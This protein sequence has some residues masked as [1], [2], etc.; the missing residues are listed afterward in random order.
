MKD[1]EELRVNKQRAILAYGAVLLIGLAAACGGGGSSSNPG[2]GF[3]PTTPAPT[4]VGSATPTPTPTPPTIASQ[5]TVHDLGA[6]RF[7]GDGQAAGAAI[8]GATVI[9]GPTLVVG[10]TPPPT[11]PSGDSAT[12]TAS[13]GS[14][15]IGNYTTTG[16]TY[17]MVF[18]ASGDTAHISLHA[19]AKV[20]NGQIRPLY[21]HSLTA[22]E[23]TELAQINSDRSANGASSVVP[24][25]IA[26]ETARAHADFM[27][28]NGYYQHCIPAAA[29]YTVTSVPTTP[30]ASYA[31]QYVSPDDLYDF[32]NGA[33]QL[34]TLQNQTE[35][36]IALVP[37]WSTADASF[38]AEKGGSGYA[39]HYSNI[40][41][42]AH[43][44]VGL[45]DN[46]NGV[47]PANTGGGT[48]NVW[49]QEF[50]SPTGV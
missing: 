9:V 21:L 4:P 23:Q 27:A 15:K 1:T 11:T 29:C 42:P 37:N 50:Y 3:I 22:A 33:I 20:S 46:Q 39:G 32:M 47:A 49:I 16:T 10:A 38:M 48:W 44:W 40:V 14:Y 28:Q 30:P 13:D 36:W 35:N 31:P 34:P 7:S 43:R 41:D 6:Q 19:L 12:V 24:D 5:G 26:F 17:V 8:A 25:E 18:P 45:G 2:G